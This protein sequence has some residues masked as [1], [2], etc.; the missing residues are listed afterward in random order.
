MVVWGLTCI[1]NKVAA[2]RDGFIKAMSG[3][4][5]SGRKIYT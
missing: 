5:N 4:R 1:T 2:E 3:I